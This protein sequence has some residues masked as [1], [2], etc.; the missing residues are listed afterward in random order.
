MNG[1]V[2]I[3]GSARG[4]GTLI[5]TGALTVAAGLVRP[6]GGSD[7]A[8]ARC[9]APPVDPRL[10]RRRRCR[11]ARCCARACARQGRAVARRPGDLRRLARCRSRPRARARR[12]GAF[13]PPADATAPSLTILGPPDPFVTARAEPS[14][15][16]C[17]MPT[18]T[19]G[20]D[21]RRA[22]RCDSTARWSPTAARSARAS[23]SVRCGWR[24]RAASRGRGRVR[25]L[26]GNTAS[27]LVRVHR[28]R[29]RDAAVDRDR[30]A[31]R[32]RPGRER[33]AHWCAG[34]VTDDGAVEQVTSGRH[35]ARRAGRTLQR[36]RSRWPEGAN[37]DPRRRPRQRGPSRAR[38]R[39]R[40]CATA[41]RPAHAALAGA[42]AAPHRQEAPRSRSRPLSDD[43]RRWR[44][45]GRARRD[46]GRDRRR[47]RC[48]SP[49]ESSSGRSLWRKAPI[50][51]GSRPT[52]GA[53]NVGASR[54]RS[55]AGRCPRSRSSS[56]STARSS[57][58]ETRST[59]RGTVDVPGAIVTVNGFPAAVSG[60]SFVLDELP[61]VDGAT[62]INVVATSPAGLESAAGVTVLRDVDAPI[63]SIH[64][65]ADGSTVYQPSIVGDRHGERRGG[66]HR[67]R[68]AGGGDRQRCRRRGIEPLVPARPACRWW[69]GTT[70]SR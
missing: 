54:S 12:P 68:R 20:V 26:A 6:A 69:R 39:S 34:T 50:E 37:V 58:D 33:R 43:R 46:E 44:G 14:I 64:E 51:S 38:R 25:D 62:L 47:C 29:R 65:P 21:A 42:V 23:R 24:R 57:S 8:A 9:R 55:I 59:V 28:D 60:P 19:P 63:V 67:E 66:G 32:R 11:R 48:R 2:T 13:A 56:R 27:Q 5:A 70:R 30:G 17:S 40:S 52:D 53:G 35:V 22:S 1:A 10:R 41:S 15:S 45:G 18:P 61:L 31:G 16:R 36:A 49:A 4:A 7:G 3:E